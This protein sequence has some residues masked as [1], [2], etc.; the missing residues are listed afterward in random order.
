MALLNDIDYKNHVFEFPELTRRIGKPA[1]ATLI[2]L[3]NEVKSNAMSVHSDLGGGENGYLGLVASG[4][5]Y[6][7]LVPGA[8]PYHHPVNPGRFIIEGHETQHQIA[9]RHA[10]HAEQV[11]VFKEVIG[12][13][14]ALVQQI[15]SAVEPKY[16]KAL[17]L[18]TT[19]RLNATIPAILA[20]L[21]TNYGD[22]SPAELCTLTDQVQ[23]MQYHPQEPVDTVFTEI[24]DLATL[25][26]MAEAPMTQ[27]QKINIAYLLF[28]KTQSFS[29]G[30]TSWIA[31]PP[32]NTPG[33]ILNNIFAKLNRICAKQ[34]PSLSK[35]P[36][37]TP[38]S[39][40]LYLR[41]SKMPFSLTM[42]IIPRPLT[43]ILI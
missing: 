19:N 5:T 6:Q 18:P 22:I 1:T 15:V 9:Q 17:Q 29:R 42:P 39:W 41:E 16:L 14:R 40:N 12:I 28:Q 3:L 10:E 21:F 33:R 4:T 8:R 25:A 37:I 11:R 27:P 35:N 38:N 24:D 26:E 30:L 31:R 20:H 34:A 32:R 7:T 13:K 23:N 43:P 36:S 2:T